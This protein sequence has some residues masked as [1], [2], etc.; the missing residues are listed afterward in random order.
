MHV[1]M[2]ECM[3]CMFVYEKEWYVLYVSKEML[4]YHIDFIYRVYH[5]A[6]KVDSTYHF[7]GMRVNAS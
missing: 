5:S 3:Y 4:Q 2:Y 1:C 7:V 6:E